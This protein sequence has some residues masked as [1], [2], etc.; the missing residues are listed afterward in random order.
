[1]KWY[2]EYIHLYTC[3]REEASIKHILKI[4]FFSLCPSLYVCKMNVRSS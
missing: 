3:N 2:L 1:M 4:Y